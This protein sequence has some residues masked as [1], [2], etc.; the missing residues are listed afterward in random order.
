M[1]RKSKGNAFRM[2]SSPLSFLD[3]LSILGQ[4]GSVD[5]EETDKSKTKRGGDKSFSWSKKKQKHKETGD[6]NLL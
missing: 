3:N 5:I 2:K 6:K 1:E 4:S